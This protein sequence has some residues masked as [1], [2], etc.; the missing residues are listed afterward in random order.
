[1]LPVCHSPWVSPHGN[2]SRARPLS[3]PSV[4]SSCWSLE[5]VTHPPILSCATHVQNNNLRQW[6]IQWLHL[7]NKMFQWTLKCLVVYDKPSIY[8]TNSRQ[9]T[10]N[11]MFICNLQHYDQI[12]IYFTCSQTH[13]TLVWKLRWWLGEFKDCLLLTLSLHCAKCYQYLRF[14][15]DLRVPLYYHDPTYNSLS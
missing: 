12:W 10:F 4:E 9:H 11:E 14:G 1:M 7:N 5:L 8:N 6:Q 3:Q 13:F 15:L 2:S